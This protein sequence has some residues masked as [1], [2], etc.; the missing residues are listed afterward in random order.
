MFWRVNWL[1]KKRERQS[2]VTT[3]T[4]PKKRTLESARV[5][6]ILKSPPNSPTHRPP[7]QILLPNRSTR[8]LLPSQTISMMEVQARRG[9]ARWTEN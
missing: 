4:T 6:T 7:P 1:I 5:T 8:R 9:E 2:R 3:I